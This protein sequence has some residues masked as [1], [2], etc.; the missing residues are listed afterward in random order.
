MKTYGLLGV[1]CALA[2]V[3]ESGT[4]GLVQP[5][6]SALDIARKLNSVDSEERVRA[7]QVLAGLRPRPTDL[8]L[9]P[10]LER[11]LKDEV[12]DV[13]FYCAC[14]L[15]HLD[16]T[17][18]SSFQVV[19]GELTKPSRRGFDWY[20]AENLIGTKEQKTVV[21]F[22]SK[23]LGK[24]NG[25]L[26]KEDE[27]PDQVGSFLFVTGSLWSIGSDAKEAT[28]ELLRAMEKQKDN[29]ILSAYAG[30][31]ML[32][33]NPKELRAAEYLE[34]RLPTLIAMLDSHFAFAIDTLERLGPKAKAALPRLNEMEKTQDHGDRMKIRQAIKRIRSGD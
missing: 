31:A 15:I 25:Q 21:P 23:Q 9:I 12:F 5:K 30:G 17:K 11:G 14:L 33:I 10:L 1:A 22:L 24:L 4:S 27:F 32:K 26:V 13:R 18:A 28:P 16:P 20:A 34:K 19:I 7:S 3:Y 2:L 8:T 6:P 29:D